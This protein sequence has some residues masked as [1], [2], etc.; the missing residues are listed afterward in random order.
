MYVCTESRM[1]DRR[2]TRGLWLDELESYMGRA[3][4]SDPTTGGLR[5]LG[6]ELDAKDDAVRTI[7]E[8]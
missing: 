4:R 5:K 3:S 6:T 1:D 8:L 7:G 2:G